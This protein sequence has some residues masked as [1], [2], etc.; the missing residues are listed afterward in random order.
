MVD[1]SYDPRISKNIL[2]SEIKDFN[3]Q[4]DILFNQ[5]EHARLKSA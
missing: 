2:V 3:Q 1:D 4:F 5:L